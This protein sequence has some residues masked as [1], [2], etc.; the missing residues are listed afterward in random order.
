M[1]NEWIG[2]ET[3]EKQQ[4]HEAVETVIKQDSWE[5]KQNREEQDPRNWITDSA[6]DR[7][8]SQALS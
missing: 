5:K 3:Q 6:M 4:S 7:D 2:V 1:L 8:Y